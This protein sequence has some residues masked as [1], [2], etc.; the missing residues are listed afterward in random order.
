MRRLSVRPLEA[1]SVIGCYLADHP[2]G[3]GL[4]DSGKPAKF[5]R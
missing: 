3:D 4:L 5:K 2:A 1:S